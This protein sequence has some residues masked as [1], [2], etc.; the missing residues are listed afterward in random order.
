MDRA[1]RL[2]APGPSI[3]TAPKCRRNRAPSSSAT[4][5]SGRP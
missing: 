3:W 4:G 2:P 1:A 5:V